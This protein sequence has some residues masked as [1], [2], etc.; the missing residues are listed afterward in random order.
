M[1]GFSYGALFICA[2]KDLEE[3]LDYF[4]S[5]KAEHFIGKL[6]ADVLTPVEYLR[7]QG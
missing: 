4:V 1:I 2:A 6:D 5:W 3:R 7:R